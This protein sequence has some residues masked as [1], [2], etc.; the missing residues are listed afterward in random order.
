MTSNSNDKNWEL[1]D[2]NYYRRKY[3][4]KDNDGNVYREKRD[5][6]K[7]PLSQAPEKELN[8]DTFAVRL[9]KSQEKEFDD[10]MKKYEYTDEAF[11]YWRTR[12]Q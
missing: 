8:L 9:A 6:K 12:T 1:V 11:E 4:C 2:D 3:F 5:W 10:M 7:I